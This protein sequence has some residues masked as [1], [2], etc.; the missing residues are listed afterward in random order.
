MSAIRES[1][2][3]S[4]ENTSIDGLKVVT[5]RSFEDE[6]GNF[7]ETYHKDSFYEGGISADFVQS[8]ESSSAR[9]V[10]RGL[11]F[12]KQH[13]QAKLVRVVSGSAFD[14]AV[15]LRSGSPTFAKWF[16]VL[17]TA[18]NRKQLFIPRGF[19]HGFFALSEETVF[20][21]QCDDIYVPGD[22]GGIIWNDPTLSI[23]WPVAEHAP[24]LSEKDFSLPTFLE[25]FGPK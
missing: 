6:R 18:E 11:H 25:Q 10:L 1:G 12:Q 2:N 22:E 14:V 13:P 3:F 21:Y 5:P 20:S 4:F 17:L 9:Y 23:D 24:I 16:G 8:N 19:A 15:D 7:A